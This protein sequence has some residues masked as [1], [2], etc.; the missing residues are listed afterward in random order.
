MRTVGRIPAMCMAMKSFFHAAPE[1][2]KV[3]EIGR[4]RTDGRQAPAPA[5][6]IVAMVADEEDRKRLAN[7][8][9]RKQ[10][11][12]RFADGREEAWVIANQLDAPV[13]LCDRDLPATEW[14]DLVQLFASARHRPSVILIS[15]VVD[16]YLRQ[17]VIL[18]G[19]YDVVAKPLREDDVVRSVRLAWSYWHSAVKMSPQA[20]TRTVKKSGPF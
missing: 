7:I 19:G 6:S 1:A 4:G 17:E 11:Q 14:R 2:K 9:G 16:E 20:S 10:L 15:R 12:V 18:H 3:R 13:I 5:L 8:A